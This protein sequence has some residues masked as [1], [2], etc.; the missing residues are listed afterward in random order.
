MKVK[1]GQLF[2]LSSLLKRVATEG[3]AQN[4]NGAQSLPT[5]LFMRER[6]DPNNDAK[7]KQK[8]P[9]A[10]WRQGAAGRR[11]GGGGGYVSSRC[12]VLSFNASHF[13]ISQLASQPSAE[14]GPCFINAALNALFRGSV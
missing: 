8:N 3:M 4:A 5:D 13:L 2:I 6:V 9:T 12:S 14:Q 10:D 7:T 1:P 11:R